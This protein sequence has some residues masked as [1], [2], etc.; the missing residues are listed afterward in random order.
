MEEA[1]TV[2]GILEITPQKHGFTRNPANN[3]LPSEQDAFVPPALIQKYK[4]RE[5][6][7]IEAVTQQAKGRG[8]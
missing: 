5:G 3:F 4:L 7:E 1:G 8:S 6:V 2:R